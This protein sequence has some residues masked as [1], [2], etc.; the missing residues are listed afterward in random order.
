MR[1]IKIKVRYKG[2]NYCGWQSQI[3]GIAVQDVIEGSIKKVTGEE[4]KLIGAGRTDAGVHALGQVANF[5]T[6]SSISD[7][8][9][10]LAL[11]ANLPDDIVIYDAEEVNID[12]NARYD[13]K[14][15][16]YRYCI[17]NSRY[18]PG[19]FDEYCY[20]LPHEVDMEIMQE[21]SKIF[22]GTHDFKNFMSS[23][24]SIK[25]TVRTVW[26]ID[27][28]KRKEIIYVDVK[29]EGFLYN[30]VRRIAGC[31]IE[32]G[33]GKRDISDVANLIDNEGYFFSYMTLPAKGL[34]LV[35][36]YY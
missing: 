4:V 16:H 7:K 12:F 17:W 5:M 20:W 25:N 10:P 13:A 9:F 21:A 14:G 23:G 26:D 3:N 33:K 31:L 8:R 18:R 32:I 15:K 34:F 29:G 19:L 1:N 22:I 28:C 36:V 2:T 11:N 6:A 30:M 24:S 35:E 27:V